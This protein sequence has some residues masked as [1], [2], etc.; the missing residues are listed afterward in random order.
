VTAAF[1]LAAL[2]AAAPPALE[3]A[4]VT[5]R[6]AAGGLAPAVAQ[7][8][9]DGAGPRWIAYRVPVAA[10]RQM[11]C[12]DG[13]THDACCGGCTLEGRSGFSSR[14]EANVPPDE[15]EAGGGIVYLRGDGGRVDRVRMFSGSCPVDA[16][17]RALVWLSDV[18]PA[19]SLQLLASLVE[20]T[21]ER[22]T[23]S[24]AEGALA[25]IAFHDD[26]AAD[27]LLIGFARRDASS[28]VRGQALFWLSQ[29]AGEKA[30]A[31][32]TGAI[33]DDPDEDVKEKAVF[34][35]SQLPRDEGVPRLI[36]VARTNRNREVRKKAMFWLGQSE[37]PRALEFIEDVLTR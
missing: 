8:L 20:A 4:R 6:S 26:P 9:R 28:R 23:K 21:S 36:E 1:A 5:H 18:R 29:K 22:G 11:C 33:E 17:G 27:R 2:L 16:G 25:A 35:L 3:N 37:D 14:R 12:W 24:L 32:I 10:G 19:E 15:G 31:A 34:A 30:A 7:A 13:R